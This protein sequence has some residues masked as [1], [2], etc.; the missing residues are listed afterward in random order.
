MSDLFERPAHCDSGT[1][2]PC[3]ALRAILEPKDRDLGGFSVR[4]LMPSDRLKSIG[5]FVFFDHLGPARFA[6]GTGIDVRPHPHIGLATITYLFD[7]EILHRD[8]LGHVQPI[9]PGEINWM[10]AGRGIVHSERT[11]PALRQ[12]GHDLHALQL[13]VALPVD[14]EETDPEFLHYDAA[15]L[16]SVEKA[17]LSL[18]VMIGEAFGVQSPVKT[19]SPTLYLDARLAKG[20]ILPLPDG[21][22]ER[23]V[24]VVAGSLAARDRLIPSHHLAVFDET[25]GI[26]L[27][28]TEDSRLVVIGGKPLGKRTVWWNL[29][30]S[31]RELI[32]Q[33]KADWKNGRFPQVPGETEFIPLPG[34]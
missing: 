9:R 29:V 7:G 21:V 13:W 27:I 30:A 19:Y 11:P 26:E 14:Q 1:S 34:D 24:Y 15:Q 33:A 18:R 3:A 31:R 28:A 10:T 2:A 4:R 17:G 20:S 16:P 23:A 8:S 12:A 22:E 6:P 5:P 25:P 32:E